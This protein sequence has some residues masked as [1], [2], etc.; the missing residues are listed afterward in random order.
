MPNN[1]PTKSAFLL[2]SQISLLSVLLKEKREAV[3]TEFKTFPTEDQV[4]EN[5]LEAR[6]VLI[7]GAQAIRG[8]LAGAITDIDGLLKHLGFGGMQVN[9][10]DLKRIAEAG[11]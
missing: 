10:D 3:E 8:H 1:R 4:F 11:G 9:Q 7:H 5:E 2:A 6:E